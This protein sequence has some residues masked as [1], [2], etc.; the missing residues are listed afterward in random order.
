LHDS[1]TEI[2]ATVYAVNSPNSY[3]DSSTNR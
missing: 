2:L 1:S 3:T